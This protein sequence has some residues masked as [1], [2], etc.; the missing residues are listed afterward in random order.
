MDDC[1]SWPGTYLTDGD[2][3]DV[4]ESRVLVRLVMGGARDMSGGAGPE[5]ASAQDRRLVYLHLSVTGGSGSCR[6]G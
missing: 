4:V 2:G 3:T 6:K 1:L 5:T